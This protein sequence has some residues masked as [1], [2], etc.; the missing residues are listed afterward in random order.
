MKKAELRKMVEEYGIL[1]SKSDSDDQVN[2]KILKKIKE[3]ERRY[4][5]ET[6]QDLSLS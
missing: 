1:K 6:G 2:P 4:F 5:H 3:I